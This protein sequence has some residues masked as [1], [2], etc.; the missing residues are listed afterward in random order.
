LTWRAFDDL[1]N[2]WLDGILYLVKVSQ[3]PGISGDDEDHKTYANYPE[4]YEYS[5][6]PSDRHWHGGHGVGSFVVGEK[7]LRI[8]VIGG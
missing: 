2:R 6:L 1:R 8:V 7:G 3:C 5:L 4:W